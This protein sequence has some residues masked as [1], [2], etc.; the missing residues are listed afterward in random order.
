MLNFIQ[1]W[2][3]QMKELLTIRMGEVVTLVVSNARKSGFHAARN[4]CDQPYRVL[5]EEMK[6][7]R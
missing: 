2:T 4:C 5:V 6:T 3:K 1:I 7:V